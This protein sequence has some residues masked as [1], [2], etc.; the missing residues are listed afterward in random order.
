MAFLA[1]VTLLLSAL[2]IPGAG[3]VVEATTGG[4]LAEGRAWVSALSLAGIAAA[5]A[6][7][8]VLQSRGALAGLGLPAFARRSAEAWLGLPAAAGTLVVRPTR[9]LASTLA[10]FDDRVIDAGARAAAWTGRRISGFLSRWAELVLDG[11]LAS[12]VASGTLRSASFS[13]LAD[14]HGVDAAVERTAAGVGR[15]GRWAPGVQTGLVH[16]YLAIL[17]A[18]FL[19]VVVLTVLGR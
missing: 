14:D 3:R 18:G 6:L 4:V 16:H 7:V 12:G 19:A 2:W 8:A 11:A 5:F 9:A 17:F 13:R 10:A 1:A 15:A